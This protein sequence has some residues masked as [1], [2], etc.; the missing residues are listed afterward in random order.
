M[1]KMML[2]V[3]SAAMLVLSAC[4]SSQDAGDSSAE[5]A[6]VDLNAFYSG[7]AEEYHWSEDPQQ[8]GENDLLMS[9]IEG[10]MLDSYYPGLSDLATKQLVAK[11]PMMS[12]LV[13]EVVFLQCETEEDAQKAEEILQAR[14]D[15]QVGDDTN[16]GGAWYPESIEAWKSA[17]VIRHGMYVAL[18]ASA[19]HQSEIAEAFNAQ[20][21]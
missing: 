2:F 13:N 18:I 7:L 11:A 20:F 4:G 16:P 1:K 6:D 21:A 12:S 5:T 3:L 17:Q 14:I 15:Y 8:S 19:E 10:E 9:S